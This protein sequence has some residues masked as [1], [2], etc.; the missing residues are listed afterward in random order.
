[1]P[2]SV[3]TCAAEKP[4]PD[5]FGEANVTVGVDCRKL[6]LLNIQA[7]FVDGAAGKWP[8]RVTVTGVESVRQHT[9]SRPGKA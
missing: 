7:L 5:H 2:L 1:M 6:V 3:I 9:R 4:V 8:P